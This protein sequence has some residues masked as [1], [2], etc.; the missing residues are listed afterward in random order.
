MPGSG[1]IMCSSEVSGL[2]GENSQGIRILRA[3]RCRHSG[4]MTR[5]VWR[6][7]AQ[8]PNMIF[9]LHQGGEAGVNQKNGARVGGS[10]QGRVCWAEVA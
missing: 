9:K 1:H 6:V 7:S 5:P 2:R 10:E 3:G 8:L 4:E